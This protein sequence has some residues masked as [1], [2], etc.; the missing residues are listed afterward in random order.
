MQQYSSVDPLEM[1]ELAHMGHFPIEGA[2][3][4]SEAA[5]RVLEAS[6]DVQ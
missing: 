3:A 2:H 4:V 1:L 5:V 6:G